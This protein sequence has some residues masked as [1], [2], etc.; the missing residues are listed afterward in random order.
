MKKV[1]VI[2][3]VAALACVSLGQG[4]GGRRMMMSGRGMGGG[5]RLAMRSDVA[6]ELKLTADQKLKLED[7]IESMRGQGFRMGGPGGPSDGPPDMA[8]MRKMMAKRRADEQAALAKILDAEQ[9]KRLKELGIQRSG[10]SALM[11]PEVQKELKFSA[12]Q[13]KKVDD[14]QAKQM[15]AMQAI[16][17]KMRN[18]EI[19]FE[20]ARPLFEKN[21]KI[22]EEELGKILTAEQKTDFAKMGGSPFKFDPDEERGPRG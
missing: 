14:L 10:N 5:A 19:D 8:E 11:D 2:A 7:M 12:A 15:E 18:Q 17:E 13:T 4:G 9:S 20:A 1:F 3:L 21:Q 16:G 6:K 22:M